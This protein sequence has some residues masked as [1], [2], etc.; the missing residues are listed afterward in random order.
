[1]KKFFKTIRFNITTDE[2]REETRVRLQNKLKSQPNCGQSIY[3]IKGVDE[4]KDILFVNNSQNT[5]V[6]DRETNF[7]WRF[8]YNDGHPCIFITFTAINKNLLDYSAIICLETN[9]LTEGKNKSITAYESGY[10]GVDDRL[11]NITWLPIESIQLNK[12]YCIYIIGF[13]YNVQNIKREY[14]SELFGPW[15]FAK[16]KNRFRE[17]PND[18]KIHLNIRPSIRVY[19]KTNSGCISEN[20]HHIYHNLPDYVNVEYFLNDEY[21]I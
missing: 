3:H 14:P 21:Q 8:G 12:E 2:S 20:T 15:K 9:T 1:M 4:G 10:A 6:V 19:G 18:W 11:K 7:T 16:Y 17:I 5:N 13:G